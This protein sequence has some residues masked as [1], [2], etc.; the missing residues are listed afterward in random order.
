[1]Q[2]FSSLPHGFGLIWSSLN[3]SYF[4]RSL[5]EIEIDCVEEM[6][7]ELGI[8]YPWI[9]YGWDFG[10]P[11]EEWVSAS[12]RAEWR[13][14]KRQRID[15]DLRRLATLG[16]DAIRWFI[17]GD[18]TNYGM[19]AEAPQFSNGLWQ[20]DPLPMNHPFYSQ[21]REDFRFVLETCRTHRLKLLPSLIDFHWAH[22]G[23]VVADGSGVVKGGRSQILTDPARSERFF[24]AVLDPLLQLS[25]GY[26]EVIAAWELMNEPEWVVAPPWYQFWQKPDPDRTVGK[27][28]MLDFLRAG[29]ARINAFEEGVF[30]STVGFAFAR[31]IRE[32]GELGITLDQFHYYP[33]EN[34]RLPV[35]L[36]SAIVGEIATAAAFRPWPDLREQAAQTVSDRLRLLEKRGYRAA[37]LWSAGVGAGPE[38]AT[39][40]TAIEQQSVRDF[41]NLNALG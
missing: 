1:L 23:E 6:F 40:W 37:Y 19:G 32:W 35:G 27:G 41:R 4:D 14:E 2:I 25:L 17:L 30:R 5:A 29:V 18:G 22:P 8:N 21:L 9:D 13:V 28:Q 7:M 24:A 33:M 31:T 10:D 12:S 26:R 3:V 15:N 36:E 34:E 20:F 16:I 38:D 39:S 11:P